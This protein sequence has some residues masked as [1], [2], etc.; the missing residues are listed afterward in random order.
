MKRS[1][2]VALLLALAVASGLLMWP[3]EAAAVK[4]KGKSR[5]AQTK[6]LMLGISQPH[7]A[8]V[9]TLL[10]GDGPTDHIG[11]I[12]LLCHASCLNELSYVLMDDG[13]SPDAVWSGAAKGLREGSSALMNAADK[14]ELADARTALKTVTSACAACH[15]AHKSI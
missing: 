8:G 6:Y 5:P 2:R 15:K 11:W 1:F 7:C 4:T 10:K 14:H 9:E 12:T 13:R 3:Q